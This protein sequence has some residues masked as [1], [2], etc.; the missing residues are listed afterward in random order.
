M[1]FRK[2]EG[3]KIETKNHFFVTIS[4]RPDLGIFGPA[5]LRASENIIQADDT[6]NFERENLS[7]QICLLVSVS[8]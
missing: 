2:S 7:S 8:V 3:E 6:G 1:I 5:E 4:S